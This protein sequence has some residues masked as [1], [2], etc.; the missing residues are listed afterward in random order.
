MVHGLVEHV[1]EF[2]RV[3]GDSDL[4]QHRKG[5]LLDSLPYRGGVKGL[6]TH[7]LVIFYGLLHQLLL[8]VVEI[9]HGEV[10][11]VSRVNFRAIVLF[12]VNH[13]KVV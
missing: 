11:D 3:L 7:T 12:P 2:H 10:V 5:S 6:E 4:T 1:M 9:F 13:V 8:R